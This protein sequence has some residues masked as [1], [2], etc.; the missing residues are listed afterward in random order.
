[1]KSIVERINNHLNEKFNILN[2]FKKKRPPKVLKEPCIYKGFKDG[3]NIYFEIK[4]DSKFDGNLKISMDGYF[5]TIIQ[6]NIHKNV[7]KINLKTVK[8]NDY[9]ITT[10][11]EVVTNDNIVGYGE[12]IFRP[13]DNKK[14][15]DVTIITL[16]KEKFTINTDI[17]VYT[18]G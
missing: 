3:N 1:M 10:T 5:K 14:H 2:V 4:Y 8:D 11:F 12:S 18:R 17:L 16:N 15:K 6:N 13:G 9:Y 7:Y